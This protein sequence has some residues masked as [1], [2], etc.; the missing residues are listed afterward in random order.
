MNTLIDAAPA[1]PVCHEMQ[2][3][4]VIIQKREASVG[5]GEV[6]IDYVGTQIVLTRTYA[7][8]E[9]VCV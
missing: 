8:L 4:D 2:S 1:R 7:G 9:C 6:H 5:V 3:L